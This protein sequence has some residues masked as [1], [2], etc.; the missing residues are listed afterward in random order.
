[1][2]QYRTSMLTKVRILLSILALGVDATRASGSPIQKVIE[3]MTKLQGQV[4]NEGELAHKSFKTYSDWC[5]KTSR[6]KQF[7]ITEGKDSKDEI[8]AVIE[9]SE[10]DAN[11]AEERVEVLSGSLASSSQDVKAVTLLRAKEKG[12]FEAMDQE[13]TSTIS[14]LSRARM[15]LKKELEKA[16]LKAS[17]T[18]LQ[19]PT[20]GMQIFAAAVGELVTT[21]QGLSAESKERLASLLQLQTGSS[22]VSNSNS[23]SDQEED[24]GEDADDDD[25]D[26]KGDS[27]GATQPYGKP[28]EAVYKAKSGGII[29]TLEKMSEEAQKAQAELRQKE[30]HEAHNAEM[31]KARLEDRIATQSKELEE[32]KK[33]LAEAKEKNR[34]F[35]RQAG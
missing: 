8:E 12:D 1:M 32:Q 6:E 21:A 31:L 13:L 29:E 26:D 18:F 30:M 15:V 3:L 27:E 25:A 20:R 34:Y 19:Q 11:D 10:S 17:G 9:K 14:T 35:Q 16:G 4:I 7:E 23:G 24:A 5:E 28:K 22:A 2:K 33:A